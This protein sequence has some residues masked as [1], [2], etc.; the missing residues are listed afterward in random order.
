MSKNILIYSFD[1]EIK[2]K[3]IYKSFNTC[4]K[5]AKYFYWSTHNISKYLNKNKL[6]KING[7]YFH[8]NYNS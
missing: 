1:L 8:S 2:N 5:A 7:S 3:V 6:Y 4:I